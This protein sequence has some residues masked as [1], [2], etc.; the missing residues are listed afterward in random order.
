MTK[1]ITKLFLICEPTYTLPKK[2]NSAVIPLLMILR[3]GNFILYFEIKT[4]L[5]DI[6]YSLK[7]LLSAWFC[8][9]VC[10]LSALLGN[11]SFDHMSN[12]FLHFPKQ[13]Q[14]CYLIT[15]AFSSFLQLWIPIAILKGTLLLFDAVYEE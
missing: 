2:V 8:C 12:L 5:R 9:L 10:L 13:M 4:F 1:L 3:N 11:L 14:I 15:L 7:L 6:F